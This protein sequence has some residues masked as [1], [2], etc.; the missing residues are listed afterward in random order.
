MD[1]LNMGL[2]KAMPFPMVPITLQKKYVEI[3][4]I[5]LANI[6]KQHLSESYQ[7]SLFNSLNQQLFAGKCLTA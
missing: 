6:D 1:G 3:K 5:V 7:E 4:A 2:I